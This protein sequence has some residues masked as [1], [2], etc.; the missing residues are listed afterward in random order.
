MSVPPVERTVGGAA[1]VS[2]ANTLAE[3]SESIGADWAEIV[4]APGVLGAPSALA[5]ID[6]VDA[7]FI[8]SFRI[9]EAEDKPGVWRMRNR[10][11]FSQAT[12]A[13]ATDALSVSQ[14]T[15]SAPDICELILTPPSAGCCKRPFRS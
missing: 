7:L 14:S 15:R 6:G 4:P 2:D 3:L 8:D 12:S 11:R 9:A 1:S 5:A 13:T 10:T